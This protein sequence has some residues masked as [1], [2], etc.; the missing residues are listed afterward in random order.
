VRFFGALHERNV[1]L[2][3]VSADAP[4]LAP[5]ERVSIE[6]ISPGLFRVIARFG[7]M[8]QPN[9]I[10]TLKRAGELGLAY[11]P[12][13]TVYIV[14]HDAAIVTSHK[15][16]PMWRKRLFAFMSRNSQM[17][18]AHYGVPMHRVIEIGSQTA[19]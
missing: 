2:T 6:T 5:E 11:E 12:N 10:A 3:F 15:G 16:M 14:G 13:A 8:E 9:V 7:F 17:A 18:S 1:L 19:L 4:R